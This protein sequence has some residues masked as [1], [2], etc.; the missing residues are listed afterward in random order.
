[1][2][3]ENNPLTKIILRNG[4]IIQ[5]ELETE[6]IEIDLDVGSK[7]S[8]YKDR[9]D[10]IYCRREGFVSGLAKIRVKGRII[11]IRNASDDGY[12][13]SFVNGGL[14]IDSMSKTSPYY[15]FLQP[16]DVI[17]TVDGKPYQPGMLTPALERLMAGKV[18]QVVIGV[19]RGDQIFHFTLIK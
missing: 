16:G 7:I 3:G 2:I 19:K 10:T 18:P 11:R 14:R 15:G 5:D 12:Q 1:M 17:I 4:D 8:I 6:D 9:I 13:F